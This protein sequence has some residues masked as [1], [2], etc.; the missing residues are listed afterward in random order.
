MS[1][2]EIK[3]KAGEGEV[4]GSSRLHSGCVFYFRSESAFRS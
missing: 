2:K 4:S 1:I 3:K